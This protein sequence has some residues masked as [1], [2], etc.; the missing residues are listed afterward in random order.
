[1]DDDGKYMIPFIVHESILTRMERVI[2][3]L[4]IILILVISMLF[5]SNAV[6]L[7]A[8]MQYDYST[9]TE[10]VSVDGKDGI[11]NYIG[12]DGDITNGENSSVE[13]EANTQEE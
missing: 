9:E 6:W 3:R 11:A 7:Y 8:W 4:I 1:M 12:N 10:T 5:I 2:K 13:N